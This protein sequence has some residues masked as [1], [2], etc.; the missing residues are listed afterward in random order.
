MLIF[1]AMQLNAK[2]AFLQHPESA[3]CSMSMRELIYSITEISLLVK[4][5][6][7]F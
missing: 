2:Q 3:E 1:V 6:S 4:L 5:N 7:R